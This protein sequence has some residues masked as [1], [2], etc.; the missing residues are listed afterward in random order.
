MHWLLF[1]TE[2]I[3]DVLGLVL[4]GMCKSLFGLDVRSHIYPLHYCSSL[5]KKFFKGT[6]VSKMLFSFLFLKRI[7]YIGLR[8]QVLWHLSAPCAH[9]TMAPHQTF[10]TC[11][12]LAQ[13]P[14]FLS[15]EIFW[16]CLNF[17]QN[18]CELL[19]FSF[20]AVSKIRLSFDSSKQNA[21]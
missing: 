20:R 14:I 8:T 3:R 7:A 12:T 4:L 1:G 21:S 18:F 5:W 13:A 6:L 11:I 17:H 19:F 16:K 10:K 15:L 2:A 9:W